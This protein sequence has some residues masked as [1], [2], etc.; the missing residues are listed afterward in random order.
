MKSLA[1]VIQSEYR[2]RVRSK[3][4]ILMTLLMP[5]LVVAAIAVVAFVVITSVS[6]EVEMKRSIAVF[7]PSGELFDG[8]VDRAPGS[9]ELARVSGS[10]ASLKRRVAVQEFDALIVLPEGL[11][12][13]ARG[14]DVYLYTSEVQSVLTQE[15]V[16]RLVL[17]VVRE[18]RLRAFDLPRDVYNAISRGV[19][20]TVLQI[21]KDNLDGSD[22][23]ASAETL[24]MIGY[25]LGIGIGIFMLVAVYGG[26]VM[27]AVM[28][29][30]TSRMAEILVSTLRPFELLLGKVVA[31]AGLAVTQILVWIVLI[32]GFAILGGII[33]GLAFT[34]EDFGEFAGMAQ[35]L[36]SMS[37][38]DMPD[39][40]LP[41]IRGDVVMV[42]IAMVLIGYFLYASMF[43]AVGAVFESNQDAQMA[44]M[45]PMAPLILSIVMVETTA[46]A[47]NSLF[48]KIGSFLP[49]TSPMLMP[50][51]MLL[52]DVP[53]W[54]VALSV[55]LAALGALGMA[56]I[57][58]RIFRVGLLVYGQKPS[59]RD[60]ARMIVQA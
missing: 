51:R 52:A 15:V 12:G 42:T 45:L 44:V 31:L 20:F 33:I 18:Q 35:S 53:G 59:L 21:D 1:V 23:E 49:F 56:W 3:T 37:Q 29:E 17:G 10:L 6:S 30:K 46:L 38:L 9:I 50:T 24:G 28:E 8:L 25:G 58:G 41:D 40:S 48:I 13:L 36:Q 26:M 11:T 27:Q 39:T 54:E 16:K 60:L 5:I 22:E 19:D 4:F 57:A 43:G 2:R 14:S 7:D 55:L 34:P 47:P 32:L